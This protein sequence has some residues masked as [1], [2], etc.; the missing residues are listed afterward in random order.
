[1]KNSWESFDIVVAC[2]GVGS[3]MRKTIQNMEPD[4]TTT[5][6]CNDY[7]Y[8]SLT[9]YGKNLHN[10]ANTSTDKYVHT[11]PSQQQCL[12]HAIPSGTLLNWNKQKY[13]EYNCTFVIS[14]SFLTNSNV[15][16]LNLFQQNF[17]IFDFESF[18]FHLTKQLQNCEIFPFRVLRC[19]R[20]HSNT[21]PIILLGRL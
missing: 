18:D 12:F 3:V 21:L 2:D 20:F 7:S 17:P 15:K 1:V 13:E 5:I 8:A 14:N 16:L 11:W 6:T 10:S 9:L 4:F 19:S